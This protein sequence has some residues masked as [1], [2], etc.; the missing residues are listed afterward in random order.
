MKL[1]S[2]PKPAAI[3]ALQLRCMQ[4]KQPHTDSS[5]RRRQTS[6]HGD[7]SCSP[8]FL[9]SGSCSVGNCGNSS[10]PNHQQLSRSSAAVTVLSAV[11][12]LSSHYRLFDAVSLATLLLYPWRPCCYILGDPAA[13][14]LATLLISVALVWCCSLHHCTVYRA[15]ALGSRSY[16]AYHSIWTTWKSKV[17]VADSLVGT[18]DD[19]ASSH[20]CRTESH[21]SL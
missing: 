11:L 15:A 19:K 20:S 6:F 14:S 21:W 2:C 10:L 4:H 3:A 9:D 13:I 17:Y 5:Q 8:E 18:T 12:L 16:P 7:S 1:S